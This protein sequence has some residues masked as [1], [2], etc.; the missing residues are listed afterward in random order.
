MGKKT[1]RGYLSQFPAHWKV[2]RM[3]K[4]LNRVKKKVDVKKTENYTQIGIRSHGKGIFYKEAVTGKELGNKS[5]FWVEPD[6]FV[7][8]IVFA[9]EMAVAK[10]TQNDVGLI[11]SHRF[12][13]YKPKPELLDLDFLLYYFKMP[14]GKYL[15]G[16]ASPGGAGRNKT[17]GQKEFAELEICIPSVNEQKEI[18]TILKT[19]DK[20]IA[21]KEKLIEEK[22]LQKEGLSYLL[23]TGKK[24]LNG[25]TEK[26]TTNKISSLLGYEQ[27][28]NYITNNFNSN[29]GNSIPV[30]TANKAFILG[31]TND[32]EGIYKNI[33]VIIFDDFTTSCQYVDF[34][35]KVK[36]SAIK[37][38]SAKK[39]HC[40]TFLY[41]RLKMI[42]LS[43]S[44]H[45]RRWIS[46][47]EPLKISVPP[48]KEQEAIAE[49][50]YSAYRE[51]SILENDL[52]ETLEQKRGLMQQLLTGKKQVVV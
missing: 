5:V 9:W 25:F 41:E 23:V 35:F 39:G 50:L 1:R 18:V 21:L 46:E 13:M 16:L 19:W 33:P 10:T 51:I 3:D 49:I 14:L 34:D 28:T 31:Y 29:N 24:R 7:V 42:N 27:P 26:W 32:T 2:Y 17:L 38:L 20:A 37:I 45:K 6:C 52:K 47:Y 36:S 22:K 43:N 4:L 40:L 30:L 44:D 8:N 15:L 12:P 11:A 48:L